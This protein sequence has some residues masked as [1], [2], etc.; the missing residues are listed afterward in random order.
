MFVIFLIIKINIIATQTLRDIVEELTDGKVKINPI[1]QLAPLLPEPVEGEQIEGGSEPGGGGGEDEPV[2]LIETK[3]A[4]KGAK[5]GVNK[6]DN[7]QQLS[8]TESK[9]HSLSTKL[10]T[11]T[12]EPHAAVPPPPLLP[13]TTTTVIIKQTSER[14]CSPMPM[15]TPPRPPS[16]PIRSLRNFDIS[17]IKQ[18]LN[19]DQA[20]AM[21]ET[22]RLKID[23]LNLTIYKLENELSQLRSDIAYRNDHMRP[24]GKNRF[25]KPTANVVPKVPDAQEK[26]DLSFTKKNAHPNTSIDVKPLPKDV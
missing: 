24:G 25:M 2:V 1:I 17:D 7:K 12:P 18:D 4:G 15:L 26:S 9:S 23:E 22:Y 10:K 11:K 20:Q 6:T 19:S 5:T 8:K 21:Q 13:P 3:P 14:G 16:T